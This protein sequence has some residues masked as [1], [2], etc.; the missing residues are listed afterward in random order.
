[1]PRVF[2]P[3]LTCV[4]F[5]NFTEPSCLQPSPTLDLQV[6]D[7]GTVEKMAKR[8]ELGILEVQAGNY[9]H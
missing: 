1:M 4:N 7:H 2:R 9:G 6:E 5:Y 3:N 8:S